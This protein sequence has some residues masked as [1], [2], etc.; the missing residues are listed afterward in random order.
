MAQTGSPCS[1][2]KAQW[3]LYWLKVTWGLIVLDCIG[4]YWIELEFELEWIQVDSGELIL[5]WMDSGG[6]SD[7]IPEKNFL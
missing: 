6:C 1:Q 4:L 7:K 2:G 3:C 5:N